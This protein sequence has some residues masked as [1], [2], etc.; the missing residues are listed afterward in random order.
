M[1]SPI[2]NAITVGIT[3]YLVIIIS[4]S[5]L[6]LLG[7]ILSCFT[8]NLLGLMAINEDSI[9]SAYISWNNTNSVLIVVWTTLSIYII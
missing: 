7:S 1:D 9:R 2:T 8:V 6:P 3:M 5:G 4:N